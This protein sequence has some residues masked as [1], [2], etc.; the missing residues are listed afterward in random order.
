MK[1][2][3]YKVNIVCFF[4]V[5]IF[6]IPSFSNAFDQCLSNGYT[7]ATINGMLTNREGAETNINELSKDFGFLYNNQPIKYKYL[8]NDT[9]LGGLQDYADVAHQK[10]FE[11]MA[12][13]DYD[14]REILND[15]S[16]DITTQKVLLVG[17]SQG[18]FYAN[19]LYNIVVDKQGGI[20]KASLGVYGV[21][22]PSSYVAGGGKYITSKSDKII[23]KLRIGNLL[24]ILPSNIDIKFDGEKD[25]DLDG[26]SFSKIYLNYESDRIRNDIN[27]ALSKLQNNNIQN[28]QNACISTP[29][30]DLVHKLAKAFYFVAD[31]TADVVKGGLI[32]TYNAGSYLANA[33]AKAFAFLF[34][35]GFSLAKSIGNFAS[36]NLATVFSSTEVNN[37]KNENPIPVSETE[38]TQQEE[39][40]QPTL[41]RDQIPEIITEIITNTTNENPLDINP[42]ITEVATEPVAQIETNIPVVLGSGGGGGNTPVIN[43]DTTPP[44]I[45]LNGLSSVDVIKGMS[46]IDAEATAIDDKDG[47]VSVITTGI[48]DFNNMIIGTYI[49]T[50]TATDL[51]N[52][53]STITRIVNVVAD[54]ISPVININ[55][56]NPEIILKNS[57]YIDAGASA[58]DNV[59]GVV[60]VTT[61]GISDINTAIA[62]TYTITYSA[63][64]LSGN[65]A[66][67]TRTVIASDG[68]K[69]DNPQSVVVSGNYAY[70]VSDQ[71]NSL[72]I[73]DVSNPEKLVHKGSAVHR[74]DGFEMYAPKGV[75]V[76]GNYA[77]VVSG[78]NA[79]EIIDVS[80]PNQPIHKST[81]YNGDGGA[82][83]IRPT[84]LVIS[85]NYAYIV[86]SGSQIIEIVDVSDPLYPK[87]K[88][89]YFGGNL[90][91][92]SSIFISGNYAYVTFSFSGIN[93]DSLQV[94]DISNPTTPVLKSILN[95]G[96]DGASINNPQSI[97]VSGNYAY[98]TSR[99][100]HSIEIIDISNVESPKHVSFIKDGDNGAS[101][102]VPISA[103]ISGNYLYV[104]LFNGSALEVLDISNPS[105]PIHKATLPNR[106]TS[107]SINYAT[108]I[109]VSG[110]YAYITSS[111]DDTFEVINIS[112]PLSPIHAGKIIN[113]EMVHTTVPTVFNSEKK[114]ISFD[115]TD[116]EPDVVGVIDEINHTVSLPVPNGTNVTTLSPT[117]IISNGAAS[118]PT[119]G[120]SKDFTNPRNYLIYAEDGST[121]NYIVSVNILPPPI[122]N[123]PPFVTSY[124]FNGVA[125]DITVNPTKLSP[126]SININ[127]SE[128]VI[129]TSIKIENISDDSIYKYFYPGVSC[130]SKNTCTET[131]DG[132]LAGDSSAPVGTYKIK[133]KIKDLSGNI[134]DDYIS[135]YVIKLDTSII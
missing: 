59:D 129:W 32:G 15:A 103:V 54:T 112:N 17:H 109:F 28:P 92:P 18:N 93:G 53:V 52:N 31:P 29:E 33:G 131:W 24:N 36:S 69:L 38:T 104:V 30:L 96:T 34:N 8:L 26:H 13:N 78:S 45:T 88:G 2:Q 23:E 9:H 98:I 97:Y 82:Q 87:H 102:Y 19:S 116:L 132:L 22:S 107:A 90:I 51:S 111:I 77:Y 66:T 46:Y 58:V 130:D 11:N 35:S 64:D 37:I 62:G 6:L 133:V 100:D 121:Q 84:S 106:I 94:L 43:T 110:N 1:I 55:G 50:Y 41:A 117:F 57:T 5:S 76:S 25:G 56:N 80:N 42:E 115:F 70:V 125:S 113:G 85:G 21:A 122:D 120:E 67:K 74:V 135:P 128:N 12:I 114:I 27:F 79:L 91:Y 4:F 65:V 99:G 89:S 73:I 14:M 71:S 124:T 63:T 47:S 72:E 40:T 75:A 119:L 49:I 20:P 108:N 95:N 123:T 3:I 7:I 134:F 118:V 83:L 68:A 126:L 86:V 81:L 16:Q 48:S 60:A 105:L 44:V 127:T 39:I 10:A 101:L 61:S